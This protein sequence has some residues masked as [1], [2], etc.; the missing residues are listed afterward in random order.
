MKVAIIHDWLVVNGGA[1]KVLKEIISVYPA[2]DIYT[3]VDYLPENKR[4]WLNGCRVFTSYIQCLPFSKRHFRKYLPFFPMAIEQFDL[5]QY[6]LVV[7]SSYAVAKGVITGP[8]QTHVSY[9][10]SPA[11]YAWDLQSEYLRESGLKPGFISKFVRFTLHNFRIWDVR[12]ANGV[13]HF[14]ANSNYVKKRILKCYRREAEVIYPPVDV[15]R[16]ELCEKKENFYFTASRI[17]S[18]KRIDLIAQA[19]AQMPDKKLKII[20]IGPQFDRV[21]E[22]ADKADNIEVLG[23]QSDEVM[24]EYLQ[25]AKAFIFAAKEDFGILP[26]EAQACG[27]PVIAYGKGGSLETVVDNVSGVYFNEQSVSSLKDAVG[28]FEMRE[29]AFR[30]STVRDNAMRFSTVGF[31]ESIIKAVNKTVAEN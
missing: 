11:R 6:D 26:V 7:S 29:S 12:T 15:E 19:F 23:Y 2:A 28:R 17:V 9:C 5:S 8:E 25:K 13:D 27:T 21:K 18:Y 24:V 30:P 10:H 14:I 22:I 16:F 3:L 20:G 4:S 31:R 1:E